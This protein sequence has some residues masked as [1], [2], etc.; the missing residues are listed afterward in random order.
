MSYIETID[1]KIKAILSLPRYTHCKNVAEFSLM[2][3]QTYAPHLYPEREKIILA[4]LFH[5]YCR[6][7]PKRELLAY[8]N[9][10]SLTCEPEE[11]AFPILLHAPVA[12]DIASKMESLNDAKIIEAI[13]WH[14]LGS[15]KMGLLGGILYCADYMEPSRAYMNRKKIESL[16][17]SATLETLTLSVVE[18]HMSHMQNSQ[19]NVAITTISLY[20]YLLGG[21]RLE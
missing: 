4:A 9:E 3:L 18:K 16:L 14:T 20:E 7:M 10:H 15:P 12:S 17:T 19:R 1:S 6:E 11:I 5:D 2:L 8:T 13:R 21:G